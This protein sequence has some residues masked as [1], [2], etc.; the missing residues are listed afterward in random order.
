[1]MLGRPACLPCT[2]CLPQETVK[3]EDLPISH[4]HIYTF[5]EQWEKLDPESTGLI[6]VTK[7]ASLMAR[8]PA[9]LGVQVR[10]H[11]DRQPVI[12]R[13]VAFYQWQVSSVTVMA[14]QVP[15]TPCLLGFAISLVRYRGLGVSEVVP[16]ALGLHQDRGTVQLL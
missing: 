16:R 15:H 11:H 1:M 2:R 14:G 12:D 3:L 8:L 4:T 9:P 10:A 6:H 7:L 13:A 5:T